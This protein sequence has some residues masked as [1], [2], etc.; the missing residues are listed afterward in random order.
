MASQKQDPH[1]GG[2]LSEMAPT[3]TTVPNDA[4][5]QRTIPSVPRPD[6]RAEHFMYDNEGVAEPSTAFA[7][8][9]TTDMPRSTRDAGTTGEVIT[10]TGDSLPADVE[11][12]RT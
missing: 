5:Q 9:N 8:D 6:Q 4:G 1:Q 3:G 12:K 7:G 11:S 2:T 10:G